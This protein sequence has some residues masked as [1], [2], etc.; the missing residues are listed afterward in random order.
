MIHRSLLVIV[1]KLCSLQVIG[2]Y[3]GTV[4]RGIGD[5]VTEPCASG[6]GLLTTQG[7]SSL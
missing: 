4:V 5:K 6:A 3:R 2:D 7:A 1:K